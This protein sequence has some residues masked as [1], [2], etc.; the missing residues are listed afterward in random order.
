MCSMIHIGRII[1][2]ELENQGR[3]VTW[4]AKQ[5]NFSRANLYNI[6]DKST[7]DT[8]VLMQISQLLKVDFFQYYTD[9]LEMRITKGCEL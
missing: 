3:S 5:L 6:F 9:E 1:R 8:A 2:Q 7:L 4:L